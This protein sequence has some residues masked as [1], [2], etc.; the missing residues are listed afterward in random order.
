MTAKDTIMS[1][2]ERDNIANNVDADSFETS[3]DYWNAIIDALLERQAGILSKA[4]MKEA[5][6]LDQS[7]VLAINEC[8]DYSPA[9]LKNFRRMVLAIFKPSWQAKLKKWS[10]EG[11]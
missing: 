6:L 3:A 2:E 11:K 7:K 4:G 1:Q 8:L 9:N 5:Y 10:L